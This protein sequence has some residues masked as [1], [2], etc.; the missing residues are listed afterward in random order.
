ML[1]QKT[2]AY[3]KAVKAFLK[4]PFQTVA[5][6]IPIYDIS[7]DLTLAYLTTWMARYRDLHRGCSPCSHLKQL[8]TKLGLN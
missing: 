1:K 2:T 6:Q 7:G 3:Y 8:F 5:H 4:F